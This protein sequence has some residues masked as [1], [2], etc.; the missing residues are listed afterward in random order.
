MLTPDEEDAIRRAFDRF[1]EVEAVYLFGSVAEGRRASTSD[2]DLG[3]VA[4]D[5]SFAE[6]KLDVLR[7]LTREGIEDVELVFLDTADTVTRHEAVRLNRLVYQREKFDRGSYYSRTVRK[8]LDL[9]PH[10]ERQR[11]SYKQRLS[12]GSS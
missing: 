12:R 11:R 6:R 8:Y 1:S 3:V 10:L 7:E 9:Q 5:A 2:L 4:G